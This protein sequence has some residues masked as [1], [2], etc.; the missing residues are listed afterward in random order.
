M[1]QFVSKLKSGRA[2]SKQQGGFTLFE[3]VI[4]MTIM[5]ILIAASIVSYQNIQ[6]KAKET[7]LKED[8]RVMRRSLDMFTADKE[9]MPQSLEDLVAAGYLHSIPID[10]ITGEADW[11]VEM[12][13]DTISR[14]GG[15][16]II[17][18]RSNASGEGSDGKSYSSY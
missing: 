12:G 3:L 9:Q 7:I 4:A 8:L 16:G 5:V 13:E 1:F 17:D 6:R 15:Q 10:P 14:E 11:A 2:G 18:I